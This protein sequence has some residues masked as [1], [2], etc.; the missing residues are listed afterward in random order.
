MFAFLYNL[1]IV[2]TKVPSAVGIIK[3]VIDIA[4][5]ATVKDILGIVLKAVQTDTI[6]NPNPPATTAEQKRL[7]QRL[8][9]RIAGRLLGI[10]DMQ[11]AVVM[12]TFNENQTA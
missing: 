6:E 3:A 7:L 4:G 2:T 10:T 1:F 9:E 5:S 12:N 11:V 8:K